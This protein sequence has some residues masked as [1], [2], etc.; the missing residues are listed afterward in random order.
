MRAGYGEKL[1]NFLSQKTNPKILIDLGPGVF[2]TAT[3]DGL[4]PEAEWHSSW[5]SP[6]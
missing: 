5:F 4:S 1:R 2:E 3:V 6:Q